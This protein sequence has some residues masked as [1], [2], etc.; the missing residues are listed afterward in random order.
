MESGDDELRWYALYVRQR[1][2]KI[3]TSH[4]VGKGYEVFL[5]TYQ[6]KRHWSDRIKV[7]EMPLF[8]R[9]IFCRFEFQERLPILTVPGV[10][11][12][13]GFGQTAT[14]VDPI[15]LNA[16]RLAVDSGLP[17]EPWPFLKVGHRVRVENGALAGLEGFVLDVKKSYKLVISLNLLNRSVAVQLDRDSVKPIPIPTTVEHSWAIS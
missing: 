10:Q 5:P 12:V 8:S 13:V 11:F 16:L 1:Y 9:Y 2:E 14:A 4:L 3:V 15:E 17:C 7:I 6:S